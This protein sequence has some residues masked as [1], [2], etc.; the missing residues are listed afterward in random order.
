MMYIHTE[1]LF[2]EEQAKIWH[3]SRQARRELEAEKILSEQIITPTR[4]L[5]YAG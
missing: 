2:R 1:Y 3:I 5:R 4:S